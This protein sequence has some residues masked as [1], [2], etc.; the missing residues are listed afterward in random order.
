MFPWEKLRLGL[1]KMKKPKRTFWQRFEQILSMEM[2]ITN[3]VNFIESWDRR[4]RLFG[5]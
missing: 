3:W 4:K 5:N 1:A 2:R